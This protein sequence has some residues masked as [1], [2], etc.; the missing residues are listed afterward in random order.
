VTLWF[1]LHE[2]RDRSHPAAFGLARLHRASAPRR[3]RQAQRGA[4]AELRPARAE[5]I[6]K[7]AERLLSVSS[8]YA[9]WR[10][11]GVALTDEEQRELARDLRGFRVQTRRP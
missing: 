2:H 5:L 11:A 10:Y 8:R 9:G 7:Q 6:P 3:H 4:A 1:L